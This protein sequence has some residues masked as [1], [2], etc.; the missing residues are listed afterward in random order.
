[1]PTYAKGNRFITKITV[2]ETYSPTRRVS[3]MFENKDDGELWELQVRAAVKA[4]KPIPDPE[5]KAPTVG[6]GDAGRV[7]NVLRSAEVLH[8]GTL[9]K[10][11][12][13][14]I[15][16]A[17]S[18]VDWV[19]PNT[20]EKDAL[21][22]AKVREYLAHC[23]NSGNATSTLNRKVSAISVLLKHSN[24]KRFDLP[25]NKFDWSKARQR[26][27]SVE[28]ERYVIALLT[29][30]GRERERDMF[31]FLCDSGL[32]PWAEA[33]VARWKQF[34]RKGGKPFVCDVVGKSGMVRD[35][36]LTERAWLAVQRQDRSAPGPWSWA[37]AFTMNDLWDRIIAAIPSLGVTEDEEKPTVWYTCRHTFASRLIMANISYGNVAKYMDNSVVM[38]QKV[39]GHLA[40]DHMHEDIAALEK[41]GSAPHLS[42]VKDR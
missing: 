6:G 40:P 34:K 23:L 21:T 1:M 12:T 28:Q 10:G 39:Y 26:F 29:T 25:W 41:Y 30:W 16:Y 36:P 9:R 11:G 38:I 19:G 32:R 24:V 31:M 5:G 14:Q 8:W 17:K 4:G 33:R 27:F 7:S 3:R 18:F 35:V 42:V 37:N 13:G 15:K 22:P 2:P 20:P